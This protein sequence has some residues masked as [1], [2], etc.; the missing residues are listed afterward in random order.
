MHIQSRQSSNFLFLDKPAGLLSEDLAKRAQSPLKP[1]HLLEKGVTGALV[2]GADQVRD[3]KQT[4]WLV[5][6][7]VSQNLELQSHDQKVR[8]R[9][10][11]R[12]PFFELWEAEGSALPSEQMRKY[13]KE[14]GLTILGD[15]TFAGTPFPHVCLHSL[16]IEIPSLEPWIC[17]VPRLFER[18]GIMRDKELV[19]IISHIDRRQ[20]LFDFLNQPEQCLRLIHTEM[21]DYRLDKLGSVLW[22]HWYCE[23]D[24]TERDLERWDFIRTLLR[25][26]LVIQKRQD[27]GQN[28]NDQKIWELGDIPATWQAK[29]GNALYEFRKQQGLSAGLFLDQRLNRERV[30]TQSAGKKILNLFSYT[31]GFSL[32]A[33]QGGAAQVTTVDLSKNFLSWSQ[34]NFRINQI[35]PSS[36]EW[37]AADS[38]LYLEGALKRNRQWDLIISDPP[39]FS[40]SEKRVFRLKDDLEELALLCSKV[41]SPKGILFFSCNLESISNHEL[42]SR[43]TA[44]FPKALI[45]SGDQDFDFELPG[46]ESNLKSFWIQFQ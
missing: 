4:Y 12:S 1:L 9:R 36:H 22:L 19:Q 40:R 3:M 28:P 5:T 20:R 6:D 35:D 44:L 16:S 31:G 25:T 15:T 14:V 30:S 39:S 11:K 29:E 21:P 8:F 41:L 27:R 7:Q 26:P 23:S 37:S 46:I 42:K 24:P 32:G 13:A 17:P 34:E 43:L 33:A 2:L 10:I 45:R 18:L 38:F